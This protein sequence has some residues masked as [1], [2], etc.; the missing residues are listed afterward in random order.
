MQFCDLFPVLFPGAGRD[1]PISEINLRHQNL[2]ILPQLAEQAAREV[3]V[4]M[5]P[6]VEGH[7]TTGMDL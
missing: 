7:H 2:L 3:Q 5:V 6:E 1:T 4:W